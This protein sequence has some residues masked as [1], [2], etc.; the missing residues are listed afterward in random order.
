MLAAEG[1]Q[2]F[3]AEF[4]GPRIEEGQWAGGAE[5]GV[6]ISC[7]MD[8]GGE[9]GGPRARGWISRAVTVKDV[10]CIYGAPLWNDGRCVGQAKRSRRKRKH[11][12][13]IAPTADHVERLA[14]V[15]VCIGTD[16]G[17]LILDCGDGGRG[18]DG[19]RLVTGWNTTMSV[20]LSARKSRS[21]R[22]RERK[23]RTRSRSLEPNGT[24][25]WEIG[26]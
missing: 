9:G 11:G 4:V 26:I 15:V 3:C 1:R 22:K 21:E 6:V 24:Y 16:D 17:G 10:N 14:S 20:V 23:G 8:F 5:S 2:D 19:E 12:G 25:A 18:F 7:G 13:E